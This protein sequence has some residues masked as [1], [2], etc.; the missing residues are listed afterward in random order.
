[1]TNDTEADI[2]PLTAVLSWYLCQILQLSQ[3]N[4]TSTARCMHPSSR[5]VW[6]LFLSVA[7][8]SSTWYMDYDEA[9]IHTEHPAAGPWSTVRISRRVAIQAN[10]IEA[11]AII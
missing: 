3:C 4:L 10:K 1:M 9:S 5:V 2:S 11:E 6:I 7:Q 8:R